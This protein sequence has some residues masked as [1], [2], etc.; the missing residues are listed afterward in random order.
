MDE[1]VTKGQMKNLIT[2][3]PAPITVKLAQTSG[4]GDNVFKLMDENVT[5]GQ[6]KNLITDKPAPITVKL[7]QTSGDADNVFKLMDS[8]VTKGQMKNLITDKPAPITVKLAQTSGDADNVFKL[9]DSNV[10]KGQM[11][12]L[13]TDKPAPITVKL[14]QVSNPVVNPP[15][16]N[17]SVNQPTVAHAAGAS[18]EQD[19]G[20]RNLIIEGVNGYDFVQTDAQNPVVN[21]P[22]NNWSVNQPSVPHDSGLAG[23]AD[24]GHDIVVD[25]HAVHFGQKEQP[26]KLAQLI[27]VAD[28]PGNYVLASVK[29]VEN[30]PGVFMIKDQDHPDSLM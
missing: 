7:A 5:K 21:P 25:G 12:N 26:S 1:N 27:P 2:D 6:M 28:K 20:L 29:D 23:D 17:W 18:P 11:K 15:F 22:F 14:A 16:N 10:T 3:K 24:L 19:L 4:D 9:M 30:T 8:N 13:I